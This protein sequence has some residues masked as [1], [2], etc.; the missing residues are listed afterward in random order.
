MFYAIVL[1]LFY[2]FIFFLLN[3]SSLVLVAFLGVSM[4]VTFLFPSKP[5]SE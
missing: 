5:D 2:V 1:I 3:P 4:F